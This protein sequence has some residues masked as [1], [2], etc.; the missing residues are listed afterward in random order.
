MNVDVSTD[1]VIHRPPQEVAAYA[2]DS[3]HAPDWYVNIK[4]VEWKTPPPLRAGSKVAFVAHFLGRSS[5]SPCGAPI[6]KIWRLS[7]QPSREFN[8]APNSRRRPRRG[9]NGAAGAGQSQPAE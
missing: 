7:R 4:S 1:A 9:S 6:A 5:P 8:S 2:A 3:Q